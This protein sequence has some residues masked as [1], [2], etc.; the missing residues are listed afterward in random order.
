MAA[1]A[2]DEGTRFNNLVHR[3]STI[4]AILGGM[5]LLAVVLINVTSVIGAAV[6]GKA[7]SGDFELTEL[8]VAIAAF[9]FLPYCQIANLNVSADIFTARVSRFW[10]SIF[11]MFASAVALLFSTLLLWRMYY[12]MLDQAA[13]DYTTAILQIP[14]WWGFLPCLFSLALLMLASFATL[15]R[16]GA[17][18]A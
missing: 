3:I 15:V 12:G 11:A 4:W 17:E 10:L 6:I 13:Y 8:G 18:L 16:A 7:V 5:V 1:A 9:S 2:Y 14:I